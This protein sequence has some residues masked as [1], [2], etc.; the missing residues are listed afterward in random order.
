MVCKVTR[1]LSHHLLVHL[2]RYLGHAQ[3][4]RLRDPDLTFGL[5]ISDAPVGTH[6]ELTCRN[7]LE[8]HSDAVGELRRLGVV[9]V[10]LC[11]YRKSTEHQ[12]NHTVRKCSHDLALLRD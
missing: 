8:L 9:I 6:H 7:Q 1:V 12:H 3:I 4:K 2:L 11:S 5:F 10:S